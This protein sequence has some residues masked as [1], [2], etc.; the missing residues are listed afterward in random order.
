[1]HSPLRSQ[2]PLDLESGD[3]TYLISF[4]DRNGLSLVLSNLQLKEVRWTTYP[5]HTISSTDGGVDG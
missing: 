1:M 5:C 4:L 2:S 3:V